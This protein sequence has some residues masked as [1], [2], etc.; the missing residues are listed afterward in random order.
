LQGIG[1]GTCPKFQAW[2]RSNG[3]CSKAFGTQ[4][5]C[6]QK[7]IDPNNDCVCAESTRIKV[8]SKDW[9]LRGGQEQRTKERNANPSYCKSLIFV[10]D[11]PETARFCCGSGGAGRN[12]TAGE[13]FA[14]PSLS[15]LG[16]RASV[17]TSDHHRRR[18]V[19]FHCDFEGKPGENGFAVWKS[20]PVT[21][22][23]RRVALT[24]ENA[25]SRSVLLAH[26]LRH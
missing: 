26:Y 3:P 4:W 5:G 7:V 25:I 23:Q 10:L 18:F 14:G 22:H 1:I 9:P 19:F 17:N 6:A 8:M 13:G 15:H 16:Y 24:N 2:N 20:V 12:R 11:C 21:L